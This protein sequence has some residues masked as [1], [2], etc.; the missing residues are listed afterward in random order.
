MRLLV[1]MLVMYNLQ[2]RYT[3]NNQRRVSYRIMQCYLS[4]EY[5]FHVDHNVSELIRNCSSDVNGFFTVVLFVI[6]LVTEGCICGLLGM[7]DGLRSG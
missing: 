1:L 3:Y 5:L 4:Q 6:Q 7:T 2:Y